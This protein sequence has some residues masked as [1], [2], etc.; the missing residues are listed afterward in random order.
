M[1]H[2]AGGL[3]AGSQKSPLQTT[4]MH[5]VPKLLGLLLLILTCDCPVRA[6]D[7]GPPMHASGIFSQEKLATRVRQAEQ[8]DSEAAYGI[9]QHYM[10]SHDPVRSLK[11][12]RIAAIQGNAKAQHAMFVFLTIP[13]AE[14]P[15]EDRIEAR[16]WL[17]KAAQAGF[18]SA[19]DALKRIDEKR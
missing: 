12:L 15:L 17:N 9:H 2:L 7:S 10:F 1:P 16:L 18:E 13:G 11:W 3:A 14:A 5:S 6:Q 8:G 19:V 4:A